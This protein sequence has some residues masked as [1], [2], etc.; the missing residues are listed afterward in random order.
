MSGSGAGGKR[1]IKEAEKLLARKPKLE[2]VVSNI[3]ERKKAEDEI[4]IFLSGIENAYDGVAF[5]EMNGD[6][7][8][9]NESAA[10]IFGYSLAEMMKLNIAV[11]SAYS[12]DAKNLEEDVA[13]QGKWRG[14]ITGIR[15]NKEK[16][17]AVLFVSVVKNEK[18]KPIGRMGVF[19]D[20]T[21][22]KKAEKALRQE[23]DKAQ[24]YLDV[25]GV[26]LVAIDAEQ[27]VGLI[28]KKGCDILGY[29][30]DEIVARN[31]FDN[32]IP[33]RIREEVRE[34]FKKV[35]QSEAD[36]PEYY[37]NPVL[38]KSG[39]ERLIAWYNT[40]LRDEK[41]SVIAT[42]SSGEDIT[43]RRKAEEELQAS[44]ERYRDLFEN[45][46]EGII[47]L[48]LDGRITGANKLVEEYGFDRAELLG[49]KL[50]DF[51]PE[52]DKAR[53][54][55]DFQ[56]LITGGRVQGQMDVIT[57]KG[58]RTVEYRDT[59][60]V[61]A[62]EVIGVQIILTDITERKKA[63]EALRESEEK[64]KSIF[65]NANDIIAS[66][67]KTGKILEVNRKIEDILGYK[68]DELIGKNFMTL[69]ILAA[70]NAAR[71][72]H[73]FK[74]SVKIG[75]FLVSRDGRNVTEVWLNHKDGHTVL[76]EANTTTIKEDGKLVGYLSVVRDITERKRAEEALRESEEKFK[77]IFEH[78]NDGVIY[79]DSSGN[80]LD[81]NER[82]ALMFGGPKQE[83][84]NRHFTEVGVFSADEI[85]TLMSNF[86][87]IFAG[88]EVV[89][90]VPIKNK[91]GQ[92]IIL[93]CS[94]SVAKTDDGADRIMVIARDITER[95]KAR[96]QIEKL[97]KFPA[98]DPYPVLRISGYGT[99][100]Y[101]NKAGSPLLKSWGCRVGESLPDRWQGFVL[102]AL[103]SG[104]SQQ[105][106]VQCDGRIFALTFAPVVDAN[107]VNIYG[108]DITELKKAEEALRETRDY[109]KNL[110]DYANAPIIVWDTKLKVT[111]FNRAFER[112]TG[113]TADEVIG[114]DLDML[115][116]QVNRQESRSK[117]AHALSSEYWESMEIPILCKNGQTRLA[118]WNSANI[119][120]EDGT[121]LLATIAQGQDITERKKG[122]EALRKSEEKW[123]SLVENA[124]NL[125]IITER[126][127]T[128]LFINYTVSGFKIE[129]T[130]GT[131]VYNY[132][133]P[134]YRDTLR[135]VIESVFQ[136]GEHDRC[137]IKGA[138][139]KSKTS[140]YDTQVGAIK[141]NG[142]V[143]SVTL[144]VTDITERKKTEEKLIEYQVKLKAMSSQMLLT[145]ERERQSLAMGLH[146]EVCQKLVL[147][148]LALESSLNLI[149]NPNVSA[150]L[151]IVC[152]GIGETIEKADSLTFE[153]SNP[154]LRQLGLVVALEKYLTDEIQKK[155][156]IAYELQSDEHLSKLPEEIKN[157]L[158]RVTRELLTNVVK[159][160]HS[161]KIKVSVRKD[162]GQIY[163]GVQ[164]DGTGFKE[165]QASSTVSKTTRFGLFSVREQLEY[166]GGHLE[167]ESEPGQGT[168][169][170][171]VVP[172]TKKAIV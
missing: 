160:A 55:S 65:D 30:E 31:W 124:P 130:I 93:E 15:K 162:C 48:D 101:G 107:Y 35:I 21:E 12:E 167:I 114:Q 78:A 22:R 163:V 81:I 71:M 27:R 169:A 44:E 159:H 59:P 69:G 97:A 111:R 120:A 99:V 152:A 17:P 105:T 57:P 11:F 16:F 138:G 62:G 45:A 170:K 70:K 88:E 126:D 106:E 74:E 60:I 96:E 92:E 155:Y 132:V 115:F 68:P 36:A 141:Y 9:A 122:E 149:S 34:V 86:E 25:A 166:L 23:R 135:K 129:E 134:E 144:I 108:H 8:Y 73:I 7:I 123:R 51:V 140:R 158:Y 104:Q 14:E 32:F 146:D 136:T 80:I 38:T 58:I 47:T 13:K 18:G 117:V 42:L 46:G 139:P 142:Q 24:R 113:H 157:C 41:G 161:H 61:R 3:T 1:P 121:T 172:L 76:L 5:T 150:S 77:S 109:L 37:E 156:G 29:K 168:T 67:T 56:A 118:L 116:L 10:N 63:E 110:I 33:E 6:V 119:Y 50:F 102:D 137:E 52:Y 66:L 127:G 75:G 89:L 90:T 84:L 145:Q 28:N 54:V 128:I 112:L 94:A 131:K 43:E 79:L 91:K 165:S 2:R 171:V 153:L 83:A 103:S 72:F 154:V 39:D 19:R 26:M 40:V 53:S 147:T 164:D 143:V 151:R 100:I 20:I 64:F 87:K 125:I 98:E 95:E 148:K 4:K 85:P 49:R 133:D 82:A